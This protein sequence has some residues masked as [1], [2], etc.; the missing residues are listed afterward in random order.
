MEEQTQPKLPPV[1]ETQPVSHG[2]RR[3]A[4]RGAKGGDDT[5]HEFTSY[6]R[7]F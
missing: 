3:S 6:G 2:G 7:W 4:R 1:P 5:L